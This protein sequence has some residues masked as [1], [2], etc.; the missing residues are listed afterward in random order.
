MD[1]VEFAYNIY[2]AILVAGASLTLVLLNQAES[3]RRHLLPRYLSVSLLLGV[4]LLLQFVASKTVIAG[5]GGWNTVDMWL[6]RLK[7]S[8][9]GIPGGVAA[10][11]FLAVYLVVL[12][13]VGY[14][15]Q[16]A[17]RDYWSRNTPP[18]ENKIS[19]N[20]INK[21]SLE[22]MP[23]E[24]IAESLNRIRDY[25]LTTVFMVFSGNVLLYTLF[26]SPPWIQG[27]FV[28]DY[29]SPLLDFT[30]EISGYMDAVVSGVLFFDMH[31]VFQPLEVS[32]LLPTLSSNP[33]SILTVGI[34]TV[35]MLVVVRNIMYLLERRYY[36][37]EY[38]TDG[39][40]TELN[41]ITELVELLMVHPLILFM[42]LYNLLT[43]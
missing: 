8:I 32:P 12:F 2:P 31:G 20:R 27:P 5:G 21:Q 41:S 24:E 11:L 23:D 42:L 39:E 9:Y 14:F 28:E 13:R 1:L 3:V 7:L 40:V 34:P 15:G 33:I 19:L 6:A 43:V 36:N 22:E 29:Y 25:G 4:F 38:I 17:V 18:F 16:R 35:L 30:N 37:F 10:S 26:L